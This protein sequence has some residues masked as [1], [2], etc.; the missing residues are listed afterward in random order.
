MRIHPLYVSMLADPSDC[1]PHEAPRRP[2]ADLTKLPTRLPFR[3]STFSKTTH[4]VLPQHGQRGP[5][6]N[7][8]DLTHPS[9]IQGGLAYRRPLQSIA[10]IPRCPVYISCESNQSPLKPFKNP[11]NQKLVAIPTTSS[12]D[13]RL[14]LLRPIATNSHPT[15]QTCLK[16][17]RLT[18][19]LPPLTDPTETET[20]WAIVRKKMANT[21]AI[22]SAGKQKAGKG[23]FSY[24]DNELESRKIAITASSR[25]PA[26][27]W[28]QSIDPASGQEL[29][30]LYLEVSPDFASE[31]Q[32]WALCFSTFDPPMSEYQWATDVFAKFLP[33]QMYPPRSKK[34]LIRLS[35]QQQPYVSMTSG[36][37]VLLPPKD[38]QVDSVSSKASQKLGPI[39]RKKRISTLPKLDT[40]DGFGLNEPTEGSFV[41]TYKEDPSIR[42]LKPDFMYASSMSLLKDNAIYTQYPAIRTFASLDLLPPYLIGEIKNTKT[43]DMEAR[44]PLALVG[45]MLLLERVKLRRLSSNSSLDDLKIFTITCC[46]TLVTIYCMKVPPGKDKSGELLS[47]EMEWFR[48]FSL[49]Y[50]DQIINMANALNCIHA[51]GRTVH[52]R[53]ILEDIEAIKGTR[54]FA[55]IDK[56][57]YEYK[58]SNTFEIGDELIIF[59]EGSKANTMAPPES[60]PLE[61]QKVID[62]KPIASIS[63]TDKSVRPKRHIPLRGSALPRPSSSNTTSHP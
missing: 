44:P 25:Q 40:K 7:S 15:K 23:T 41:T 11:P 13:S 52:L 59:D 19:R 10:N 36:N 35:R 32:D 14:P 16:P 56:R 33:V 43:K 62:P 21:T 61:G 3:T 31:I 37:Y 57:A 60:S 9:T 63:A 53:S 22:S 18:P 39:K 5:R 47:F 1:L 28:L 6:A 50:Q 8:G 54:S 49:I 2:V 4:S 55:D 29:G 51:Y 42:G 45:A 20:L 17:P 58:A 48:S 30:G 34:D 26:Y 46:G 12:R 38:L 24:R 27:E